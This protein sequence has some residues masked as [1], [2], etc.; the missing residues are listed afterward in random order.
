M[1]RKRRDSQSGTKHDKLKETV[2]RSSM[3]Q[4]PGPAPVMDRSHSDGASAHGVSRRKCWLRR[5]IVGAREWACVL[6]K[7]TLCGIEEALC[8]RQAGKVQRD[9]GASSGLFVIAAGEELTHAE[10]VGR[11]ADDIVHKESLNKS[12]TQS[13][14][15]GH[16]SEPTQ[17]WW[18]RVGRKRGSADTTIR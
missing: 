5:G 13:S 7:G 17:K 1:F 15:A 11:R 10:T 8:E 18:K 6:P 9:G 14:H 2:G 4:I 12:H 3:K 16:G